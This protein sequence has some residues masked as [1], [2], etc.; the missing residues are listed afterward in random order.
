VTRPAGHSTPTGDNRTYVHG[1]TLC[2]ID[3]NGTNTVLIGDLDQ[4]AP[5][6]SSA[7]A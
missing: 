4:A 3:A 6:A 2:R 1:V 5:T 7:P